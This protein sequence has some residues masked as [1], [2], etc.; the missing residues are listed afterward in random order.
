MKLKSRKLTGGQAA[1][2]SLRKEQVK[3]VFGLIGSATME[4]FD[5]IYHE[6]KIKI[7]QQHY[8]I[9]FIIEQINI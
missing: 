5:A 3:H 1:I 7:K 6:K 8:N 2:K 4:M 9:I